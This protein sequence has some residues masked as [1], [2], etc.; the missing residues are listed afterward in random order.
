MMLTIREFCPSDA[1]PL[2][3]VFYS[4]V[5]QTA[6]ADYT[7]QQLEAWAP[8]SRDPAKWARR[9]GAMRPFVAEVDGQVAGYADLQPAGLIDH[10]FVAAWAGRK[11]VGSALMLH[12]HGRAAGLGLRELFADVSLTAR[13]FFQKFG[14][15]V[16]EAHMADV[17]GVPL[18]NFRMAKA[19]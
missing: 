15:A 5:H 18:A 13:P 12:V 19:L 11:G 8:A 3:G 10:F 16:Q 6:A 14:F 7:P 9:V 4:A 17:R 1:E 2:W